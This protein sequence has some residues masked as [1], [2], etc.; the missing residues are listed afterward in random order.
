MA[1]TEITLI[2][3]GEVAQH[4]QTYIGKKAFHRLRINIRFEKRAGIHLNPEYVVFPRNCSY[5][6][7]AS[8]AITEIDFAGVCSYEAG[9]TSHMFE[10]CRNLKRGNFGTFTA[11]RVKDMKGMFGG[12]PAGAQFNFPH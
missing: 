8:D 10:Y 5:M 2:I 6:F 4:K 9:D 11:Y 1:N 12:C 3:P 7:T